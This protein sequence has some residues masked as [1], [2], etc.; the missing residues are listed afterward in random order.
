MSLIDALAGANVRQRLA[1]LTVELSETTSTNTV[2]LPLSQEQL[3]VRLWSVREV[4]FRKLK[5]LGDDGII[6]LIDGP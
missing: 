4:V 3:A 2:D 1:R 5:H 6:T